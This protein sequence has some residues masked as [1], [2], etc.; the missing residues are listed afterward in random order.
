MAVSPQKSLGAVFSVPRFVQA[1][2]RAAQYRQPNGGMSAISA[3]DKF[4]LSGGNPHDQTA[5]PNRR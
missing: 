5:R 3:T 2:N 4:P 1:E